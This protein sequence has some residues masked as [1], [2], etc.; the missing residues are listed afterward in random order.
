MNAFHIIYLIFSIIQVILGLHSVVMPVEIYLPMYKFGFLAI[1][2][3]F[4]L[5]V[6][7]PIYFGFAYESSQ[8]QLLSII[9]GVLFSLIGYGIST[10]FCFF[11][12]KFVFTSTGYGN[13]EKFKLCS[14]CCCSCKVIKE[15]KQS[16]QQEIHQSNEPNNESE[17]RDTRSVA[18]Y[19]VQQYRSRMQFGVSA[20]QRTFT[21]CLNPV[22]A[23]ARKRCISIEDTKRVWLD[24][25]KGLELD[26]PNADIIV[27]GLAVEQNNNDNANDNIPKERFIEVI[28]TS[29][30][31]NLKKE[32]HQNKRFSAVL[33]AKRQRNGQQWLEQVDFTQQKRD[34]R[35]NMVNYEWKT[36]QTDATSSGQG[37]ILIREN[38]EKVLEHG[39]LKNNNL[40]SSNRLEVTAVQKSLLEFRKEFIYQQPLGIRLLTDNVV[41]ICYP[42][43]G[44]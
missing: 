15:D 20:D 11:S 44:K 21:K 33:E 42:N 10:F 14:S 29:D 27:L 2:W 19:D 30:D 5:G 40:K 12:R 7:F 9:A 37:A 16:E 25:R 24:D 31:I 38:Q 22:I 4:M 17:T 1:I 3:L 18:E 43:K 35:C 41:I 13:E 28:K 32:T 36:I 34:T 26:R 8:V 23:E 6:I 39:E